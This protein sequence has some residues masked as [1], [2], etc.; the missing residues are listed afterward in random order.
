MDMKDVLRDQPDRVKPS[1]VS[2]LVG[3]V[4]GYAESDQSID[5]IH[6]I[7]PTLIA[8]EVWRDAPLGGGRYRVKT[9]LGRYTRSVDFH[10]Q[11]GYSLGARIVEPGGIP[12]IVPQGV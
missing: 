6:R 4:F 5:P 11:L 9:W 10:H 3:K 1:E 8:S 12:P 7:A 2:N